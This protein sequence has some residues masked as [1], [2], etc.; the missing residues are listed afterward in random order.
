MKFKITIKIIAIKS[1]IPKLL[2]RWKEEYFEMEN[3]PDKYKRYTTF[4][5]ALDDVLNKE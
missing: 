3:N 2:K 1:L 4:K 5:E